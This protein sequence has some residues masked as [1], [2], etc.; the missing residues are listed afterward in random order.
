MNYDSHRHNI[1]TVQKQ[2]HLKFPQTL[3]L[4]TRIPLWE[5]LEFTQLQWKLPAVKSLL[6]LDPVFSLMVPLYRYLQAH[7]HHHHFHSETV[8]IP[9]GHSLYYQQLSKLGSWKE[10]T[11]TTGFKPHYIILNY[12]ILNYIIHNNSIG[13]Q[14]FNL[15]KYFSTI[16]ATCTQH[17]LCAPA[18]AYTAIAYYKRVA[19]YRRGEEG[20][21]GD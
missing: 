17:R 12:I 20:G 18:S 5:T 6:R 2:G 1:H 15:W 3:P 8:P 19:N 9:T 14:S 7:T 21:N 10:W 11:Q 4:E 16:D 13:S